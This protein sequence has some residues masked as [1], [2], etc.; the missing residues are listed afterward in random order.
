L[1][2]G[3]GKPLANLVISPRA[4]VHHL[5]LNWRACRDGWSGRMGRVVEPDATSKR[6]A[7]QGARQT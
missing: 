7:R 3:L 2:R 1:L 6:S 5:A 4:A